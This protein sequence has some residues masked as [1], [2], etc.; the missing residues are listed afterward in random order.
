MA[1]A[2]AFV[3]SVVVGT[4][5]MIAPVVISS[6]TKTIGY[7]QTGLGVLGTGVGFALAKKHPMIAVAIGAPS[8]AALIGTFLSGQ[9]AKLLAPKSQ[10][11]SQTQSGFVST[12]QALV[13]RQ[14]IPHLNAVYANN[15]EA[16]YAQQMAALASQ[17]NIPHIGAVFAQDEGMGYVPPP[18]W[19]VAVGF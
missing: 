3:L 10:G 17:Q 5:Q 19:E 8:V 4:V 14:N 6:D 15:M 11:G 13:N 18:P 9:I 16:V 12:M 2:G 1:L 7:I